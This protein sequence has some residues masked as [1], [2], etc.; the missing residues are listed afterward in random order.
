MA[1]DLTI[2]RDLVQQYGQ[3]RHALKRKLKDRYDDLGP[4]LWALFRE[5][6]LDV[7]VDDGWWGS[8]AVATPRA[9]RW[10]GSSSGPSSRPRRS[11]RC[12]ATRP[13]PPSSDRFTP[14]GVSISSWAARLPVIRSQS[15]SCAR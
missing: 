9:A 3:D 5:G 12:E 10:I 13:E 8:P 15:R 1:M 6:T 11:T 14:G 7:S 4:V 2:A